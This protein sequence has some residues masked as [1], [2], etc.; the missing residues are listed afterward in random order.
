MAEAGPQNGP[1][2]G[3]VGPQKE[4]RCKFGG[5]AADTALGMLSGCG[6]PGPARL[7]LSPCHQ[8]VRSGGWG[9]CSKGQGPLH[10][11]WT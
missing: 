5:K 11:V 8:G 6:S 1:G 7:L 9:P 10:H 3:P 4:A 2:G